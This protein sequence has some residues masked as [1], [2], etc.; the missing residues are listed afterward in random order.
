MRAHVNVEPASFAATRR[1]FSVTR[2]CVAPALGGGCRRRLQWGGPGPQAAPTARSD[3]PSGMAIDY[4]T[5]GPGE[6][7]VLKRAPAHLEFSNALSPSQPLATVML[8]ISKPADAYAVAAARFEALAPEGAWSA[9]ALVAPFDAP[10]TSAGVVADGGLRVAGAIAGP[11]HFPMGGIVADPS[12]PIALW[13]A[14]FTVDDF[15]PR[16]V[17][18]VADIDRY[19]VYTSAGSG[20]SERRFTPD[21]RGA[22]VV[23]PAPGGVALLAAALGWAARRT[24][25]R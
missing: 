24:R 6:L 7:E 1:T 15:T 5:L 19:D 8:W 23:V 12:D 3:Q 16:E 20:F 2:M 18:L 22:I 25:R 21:A 13:Q 10:G 4:R 17:V 14:T 11:L 9:P